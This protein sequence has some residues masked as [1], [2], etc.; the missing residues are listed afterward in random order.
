MLILTD[1]GGITGQELVGS[2]TR[3]IGICVDV[4]PQVNLI[5]RLFHLVEFACLAG[6]LLNA[7][8]SVK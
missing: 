6:H 4:V 3:L 7:T 5:L 8:M 2:L 1:A